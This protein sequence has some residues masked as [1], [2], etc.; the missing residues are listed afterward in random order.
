[1]QELSKT[2]CMA[3]RCLMT[4]RHGPLRLYQ[5]IPDN[6][7]YYFEPLVAYACSTKLLAQYFTVPLTSPI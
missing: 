6:L 5:P 1:M 7:I 3:A 4:V 2:G